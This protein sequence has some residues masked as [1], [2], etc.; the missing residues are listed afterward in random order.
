MKRILILEDDD[1]LRRT[2]GRALR[3]RGHEVNEVES[4]GALSRGVSAADLDWAIVD[5][6][7]PDGSG[8]EAV[9]SLLSAKPALRIVI[10]TGYGSIASAV[11]AVRRGAIDYLAKPADVDQL[12]DVLDPGRGS[13]GDLSLRAPS[14]ERVEW[15]HIQRVL[16][17]CGGNVTKAAAALGIHRRTLQ[18]KLSYRPRGD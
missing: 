7:L 10:L 3:K 2:L 17:D 14:L 12:L 8:L 1:Q 9:D 15:E 4:L 5:L 13:E 18:R 16:H 11:D 6:A